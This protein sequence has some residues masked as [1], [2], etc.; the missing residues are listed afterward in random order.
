MNRGCHVNNSGAGVNQTCQSSPEEG[1]VPG[2]DDHP[3]SASASLPMLKHRI[4]RQRVRSS[5]DEVAAWG[6]LSRRYINV[7][8]GRPIA[9]QKAVMLMDSRS[10][11]L[12]LS[13]RW[14]GALAGFF[15]K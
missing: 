14:G 5:R 13:A 11:G 6:D 10:A 2:V 3:G 15:P 1:P 4:S 9:S 7:E 12:I 8:V